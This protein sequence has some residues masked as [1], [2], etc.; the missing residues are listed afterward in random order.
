MKHGERRVTLIAT[1]EEVVLQTE[2]PNPYGNE[3]SAI[4][5]NTYDASYEG[6]DETGHHWSESG[7]RGWGATEAEAIEDLFDQ[8]LDEVAA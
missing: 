5:A 4:D 3:W 2:Q 1:R 8:I 7:G 6:E